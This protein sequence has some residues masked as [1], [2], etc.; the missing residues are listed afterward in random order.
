MKAQSTEAAALAETLD[1]CQ[2]LAQEGIFLSHLHCTVA[3]LAFTDDWPTANMFWERAHTDQ[4]TAL[5]KLVEEARAS[6]LKAR[7]RPRPPL[8]ESDRDRDYRRD[9]R[10]RD[11]ELRDRDRDR[12]RDQDRPLRDRPIRDGRPPRRY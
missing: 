6:A 2:A 10:E 8:R 11:R 3:E 5:T 7:P 12:D 1:K 4:G 9:Q